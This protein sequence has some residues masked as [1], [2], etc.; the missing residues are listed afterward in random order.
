MAQRWAVYVSCVVLAQ[1]LGA[2]TGQ[3]AADN[4]AAPATQQKVSAAQQAEG[5]LVI[6]FGDSLYAGYGVAQNESFPYE[7]GRALLAQGIAVNIRNAGVSG[8]TT[9][10]GLQRLAFTLDGLPRKPDLLLLG[11]GGNDML[12]GLDPAQSKANLRAIL[13]ELKGRGIP[14]LMTG[15]L[16]APNMGKEYAQQ[17]NAIY[18][19]LAEE[20][21]VPLYPFFLDGVIGNTR[22]MQTDAIHPN[23][24]GIDAVVNKVVPL[25]AQALVG[26]EAGA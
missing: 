13:A 11:L 2:C 26:G 3:P 5:K 1:S 14:V 19:A 16:A 17:F 10:G 9:Q 22:L 15:I 7:L 18:P 8:E 21:D 4:A 25:V 24:A 6:A 12:R 20:F 23:A